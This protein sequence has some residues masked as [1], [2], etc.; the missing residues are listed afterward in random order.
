MINL[1]D[2]LF[3]P[4]TAQVIKQMPII[5]SEGEDLLCW[6]LTPTEKFSS[7]SAYRLCL[8]VMQEQGEP[9][10]RTIST[11]EKLILKQIWKA[12]DI[13]PRIQTF[14]WRLIRR[15]LPTGKRMGKYSKHI[16][17]LCARCGVQEDELHILF[18]CT[19]ARAAWFARPWFIR[20]DQLLENS[21]SISIILLNLVNSN[22]PHATLSNIFTFMWC[23]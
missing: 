20:T 4:E 9:Q 17:K 22:H 21:N 11:D 2:A 5:Q 6:K 10:P 7:K 18:N 14:A 13:A 12:K 1:I 16:S 15:A 19:F 23:L 8:Q 3:V